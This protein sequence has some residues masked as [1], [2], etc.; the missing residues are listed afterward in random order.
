MAGKIKSMKISVTPS[1]IE[2]MTLQLV[3]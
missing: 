2:P 3:V 1:G